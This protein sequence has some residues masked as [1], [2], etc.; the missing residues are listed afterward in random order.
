MLLT[1]DEAR[2][3]LD[4]VLCLDRSWRELLE[5]DREAFLCQLMGA[6]LSRIPFQSL[7]VLV[8]RAVPSLDEVKRDV[9]S[10]AGGLC[11]TMNVFFKHLLDALGGFDAGFALCTIHGSIGHGTVLVRGLAG[12]DELHCVDVGC[13]YVLPA[14]LQ[15]P[16][17][18]DE[19]TSLRHGQL[20]VELTLQERHGEA[21]IQRHHTANGRRSLFWE[22]DPRRCS[23]DEVARAVRPTY[24]SYD[25][26]RVVLAEDSSLSMIAFKDDLL[27]TED[28]LTSELQMRRFA[29][30][31]QRLRA[32]LRHLRWLDP[33]RIRAGL[34]LAGWRKGAFH[35][36]G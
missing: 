20:I 1:R 32:L 21:V 29:D 13:G 2:S 26:L 30:D 11:F 22:M 35:G 10:R 5:T 27:L 8:S 34:D 15:L 36:R 18:L 9:L 19:T 28:P 3:F 33:D 24:E 16:A 14:P 12:P 17:G 25:R 23:L 4:E 7:D 31:R 6:Y